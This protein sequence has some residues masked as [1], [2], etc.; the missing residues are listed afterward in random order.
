MSAF[1]WMLSKVGHRDDETFRQ[2]VHSIAREHGVSELRVKTDMYL[3]ALT[4]G[5]GFTDYF[6]GEYWGASK[7]R[8]DTFVTTRSFY[9]LLHYLNDDAFSTIIRDKLVF[10]DMFRPYLG[11]GFLNLGAATPEEFARFIDGK[12]AVFAKT[13]TGFRSMGVEKV[14]VA[15]VT[16]E[17]DARELFD[18]L[19]ARGFSLVEEPIEQL[20]DLDEVNP[21]SVASFRVATLVKDGRSHVLGNALRMNKGVSDMT[22]LHDVMFGKLREDG[23]FVLPPVDG[24]GARFEAHPVTGKRFADVRIP[25]VREA[26]DLC[27]RA[28]LEVPQVRYVGWDVA[29]STNGPVLI[30]GNAYPSYQLLQYVKVTGKATGHLKEIAEVLGDE[31]DRIKF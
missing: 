4:R 20:A 2:M 3:N 26:F 23:A 7:E 11:R 30:E 9:H 16:D 29:F 17:G 31:M 24:L 5:A 19:K 22:E 10:C 14:D 28:A 6:R 27:L 21:G 15:G 8:K 18:D 25:Q 13:A 12:R 1:T